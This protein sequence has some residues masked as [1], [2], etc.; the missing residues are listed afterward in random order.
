MRIERVDI[1]QAGIYLLVKVV[2]DE[3]RR[4]LG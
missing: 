1:V 3:G 4:R 2:T